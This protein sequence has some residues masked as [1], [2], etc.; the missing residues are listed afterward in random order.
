MEVKMDIEKY[1]R[2]F[3]AVTK[4]PSLDAMKFFMNEFRRTT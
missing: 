2:N 1:L 3:D 4:E